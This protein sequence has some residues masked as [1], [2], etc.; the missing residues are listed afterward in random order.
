MLDRPTRWAEPFRLDECRL[1]TEP[2]QIGG[3]DFNQGSWAADIHARLFG[4]RP[5]DRLEHRAVNPAIESG[6]SIRL[7]ASKRVIDLEGCVLLCQT[8]ELVPVDHVLP[9]ARRVQ[10]SHRESMPSANV[11]GSERDV[12]MAQ[13]CH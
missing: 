3:H 13:H 1:M 5:C 9:S 12:T 8:S 10:Q 6:P 4:R 11:G 7:L 2:D